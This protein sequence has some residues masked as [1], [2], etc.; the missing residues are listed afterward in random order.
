[1]STDTGAFK[2]CPNC[3]RP[4]ESRRDFLDDPELSFLGYQAFV[5][6]GILGLFMFN[7]HPCGTTMAVSAERFEDLRP[8][9]MYETS[10]PRPAVAPAYCL[11]AGDP[12]DCPPQCEC[13]FVRE[14]VE[15][16]TGGEARAA[17]SPKT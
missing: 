17:R 12:A 9:P 5:R 3:G 11:D 1:M 8:G 7:H 2:T 14:V 15:L 6:D 16:I 4:W 10:H 13:G